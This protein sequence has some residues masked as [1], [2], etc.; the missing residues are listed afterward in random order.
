[1][2]VVDVVVLLGVCVGH[3][4]LLSISNNWWFAL[5][6]P[7]R[8]LTFLR[9]LHGVLVL[10]GIAAF[11]YAYPLTLS[12][13]AAAASHNI[14]GT[15]APL[16]ADLCAAVA[17]VGVPVVTAIRLLKPNPAVLLSNHR[18]TFDVARELGYKP[19]GTGKY[20][21][22]AKLPFNQVFQVELAEQTL[23]LP[24]LPAAWDGLTILH[25]S[26]LH[27][28]GSPD[29][30][31]Y[32]RVLER[33]RD[34]QPDIIAFTGDLVDSD[35]H[36]R[37]ILPVLGKLR[38][39]IAGFAILGNHDSWHE[40][41]VLRRRLRRCGYDVLNNRWT[42]IQVRGQPLVV[43]GHEGPWFRPAPDMLGC[44][45]GPFRL[46]LSHTPDNIAWAR[47][48][49]IDLVLAG[50]NHGGQIRF[51]LIGSV[52]VPSSY[53]TRYD[54]GIFYEPPTVLHVSRGLAGQHPLRYNCRPEVSRLIL[55][56]R[57]DANTSA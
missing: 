33:C 23:W 17:F 27:L 32:Q 41:G 42:Q 6:L 2:H 21:L 31:F 9:V 25:V 3:I 29:K 48:H 15:A 40:P 11:I 39:R 43:V 50:H 30:I 18:Q 19:A 37:W 57:K 55:K 26:D 24:R 8:F 28:C 45:D 14:V 49:N 7:H 51:P 1:M 20:R 16:Y 56:A 47:Q 5:A 10:G 13:P 54:C 53:G 52:L 22:L 44:P 38:W 34:W 4:T 36:H 35:K 46:C 12:L